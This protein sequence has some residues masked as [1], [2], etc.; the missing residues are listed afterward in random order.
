MFDPTMRKINN[1]VRISST[2]ALTCVVKATDGTTVLLHKIVCSIEAV[3]LISRRSAS[4]LQVHE[5]F[6]QLI[7]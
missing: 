5:L 6:Q 4:V 2:Y 1:M 7:D 3:W